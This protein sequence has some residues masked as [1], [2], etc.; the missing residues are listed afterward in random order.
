MVDKLADLIAVI[1]DLAVPDNIAT[2]RN[3]LGYT[4]SKIW[5][6][7]GKPEWAKEYRDARA[8]MPWDS[9]AYIA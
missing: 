6:F 8:V 2:G 5:D 1:S 4:P 3:F 9:E 7:G